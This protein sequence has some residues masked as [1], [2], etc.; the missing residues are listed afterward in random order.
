MV[1]NPQLKGI[2]NKDVLREKA[3][4]TKNANKKLSE[5]V[6]DIYGK[7]AKKQPK[8]MDGYRAGNKEGDKIEFK[9]ASEDQM[10]LVNKDPK[11]RKKFGDHLTK[12]PIW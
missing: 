3:L 11:L 2:V 12:L 10:K 1:K 6:L 9:G 4:D 7:A 8:A 5:I